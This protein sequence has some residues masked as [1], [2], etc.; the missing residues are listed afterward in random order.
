ME[1][2]VVLAELNFVVDLSARYQTDCHRNR[3][4][5][6][7]PRRCD[8]ILMACGGSGAVIGWIHHEVLCSTFD[9]AKERERDGKYYD[10]FCP[11]DNLDCD[12][13][14]VG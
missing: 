13:Q 2:C 8:M 6:Y 10:W 3:Q 14:F 1:V 5:I 11:I 12:Q 4:V 9:K 7:D